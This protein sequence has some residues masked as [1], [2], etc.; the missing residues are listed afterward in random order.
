MTSRPKIPISW[1]DSFRSILTMEESRGFDNKAV[2][3]GLDR[4]IQTWA[5][6]MAAQLGDGQAASGLLGTHYS[7]MT[8]E[9]RGI[10]ATEW[11]SFL[12]AGSIDT[13]DNGAE[14]DVPEPPKA[15]KTRSSPSSERTK[16]PDTRQPAPPGGL[17]VDSP[18]DRLRGVDTKSVTRFQRLE[19]ATIRDLLYLF[20]R[21]HID[22]SIIARISEVSPDEPCTVVGIIWESRTIK[23]G[24]QG[25]RVDTEAVLSDE[26]GNIKVVWF[27]QRH[28]ARTLKPNT[29]IS[30]SGKAGVFKGQLVFESPDYE[31]L[32]HGQTPI[33]TGRLVPVYPLTEGLTARN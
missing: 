33:H 26:T 11:R 1:V 7:G 8:G 4:F 13:G 3:G 5:E 18:V 17:P 23:Q 2:M 12:D 9:E 29:R 31:L 15:K 6:E 32:D 24:Y 28:L 20:P 27:G 19:V 25:K 22:Y 14:I 10:W 21:R 30:I 16:K